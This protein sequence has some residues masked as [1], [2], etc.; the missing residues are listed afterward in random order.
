MRCRYCL[1]QYEITFE[2]IR[3]VLNA[4]PQQNVSI[5]L[6]KSQNT[7][8]PRTYSLKGET[9]KY[10][11]SVEYDTCSG[12]LVISTTNEDPGAAHKQLKVS[13]QTVFRVKIGTNI[14]IF[15]LKKYRFICVKNCSLLHKRVIAL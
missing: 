4:H 13:V 6:E 1:Q 10:P 2:A 3:H 8:I 12:K 14:A 5:L 9:V 11:A 7:F 15:L